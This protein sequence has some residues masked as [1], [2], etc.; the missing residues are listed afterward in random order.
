[1]SS[2]KIV[3]EELSV[4]IVEAEILRQV[5]MT[6]GAGEFLSVIGPKGAG[7]STLLRC[8]DGILEPSAGRVVIDGRPLADFSRRELARQLFVS[9][10]TV[11]THLQSIRRKL[12]LT[13]REDIAAR[14]REL[15]LLPP[16][17]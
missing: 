13:G 15:G 3:A 16:A 5:S 11:K 9:E 8:L 7:K 17:E 12:G 4:H 10:N 6:V 1:M 14:A 2:P